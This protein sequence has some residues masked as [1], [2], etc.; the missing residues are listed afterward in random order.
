M[1]DV[2]FVDR[3]AKLGKDAA[4]S[5]V[6]QGRYK[7]FVLRET[8]EIV[9]VEKDI[10][11]FN[12]CA[13][14]GSIEAFCAHI[15][16]YFFPEKTMI[17]VATSGADAK[18]DATR[19]EKDAQSCSMPFYGGDLPDREMTYET[20]LTFLDRNAGFISGVVGGEELFS[21]DEIRESLKMIVFSSSDKMTLSD[22]GPIINVVFEKREGVEPATT[23]LP[24]IL[25]V[26][27]RYGLREYIIPCRFRLSIS[28]K[29]FNL[30]QIP[31]DGAMDEYL[32]RAITDIKANLGDGWHVVQGI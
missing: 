21:E 4:A 1:L 7:D 16:R 11:P 2:S 17:V 19:N 18:F 14:L 28:G 22:N 30:S 15:R 12:P 26:K 24:K 25:Q 32:G 8:G 3:I 23:K 6:F 5:N 9:E 13:K 10:A 29:S 20:F 31:R 27:L